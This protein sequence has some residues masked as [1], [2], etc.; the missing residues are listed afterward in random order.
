MPV[1]LLRC[2]NYSKEEEEGKVKRVR[3][4]SDHEPKPFV[5]PLILGDNMAVLQQGSDQEEHPMSILKGA[6]TKKI[7]FNIAVRQSSA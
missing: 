2:K 4:D 3:R 1:R 7:G 6:T 5:G